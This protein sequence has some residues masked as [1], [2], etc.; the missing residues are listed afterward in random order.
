METSSREWDPGKGYKRNRF[1]NG[2]GYKC[3]RV[4]RISTNVA[5]CFVYRIYLKCKNRDQNDNPCL[6]HASCDSDIWPDTPESINNFRTNG[7]HSCVLG[8]DYAT[9]K[10]EL[11][12]KDPLFVDIPQA[13]PSGVDGPTP[14]LDSDLGP[15]ASEF[16]EENPIPILDETPAVVAVPTPVKAVSRTVVEA[17]ELT[18][19]E[20]K[21]L[22]R[23]LSGAQLIEHAAGVVNG[24]IFE[25][26]RTSKERDKLCTAVDS[27][28]E[29]ILPLLRNPNVS[30]EAVSRVP[31]EVVPV[32]TSQLRNPPVASRLSDTVVLAG[33]VTVDSIFSGAN[34]IIV[35]IRDDLPLSYVRKKWLCDQR[36]NF[37][38]L[39]GE[40]NLFWDTRP[41]SLP[42][43]EKS[44][45][46]PGQGQLDSDQLITLM[47]ILD[48]LECPRSEV[49]TPILGTALTRHQIDNLAGRTEESLSAAKAFLEEY[50]VEPVHRRIL[51][52]FPEFKC[53]EY[54]LIGQTAGLSSPGIIH[55]DNQVARS[56]SVLLPLEGSLG[57]DYF[58][59]G[60]TFH[61]EVAP[62]ECLVHDGMTLHRGNWP[63]ETKDDWFRL[64][65]QFASRPEDLAGSQTFPAAVGDP[66][67][68]PGYDAA[69]VLKAHT[70]EETDFHG[71]ITRAK[72]RRTRR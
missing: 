8:V 11:P 14:D 45:L 59:D 66:H 38:C 70:E 50:L 29:T 34:S 30:S 1:I 68:P 24:L 36:D 71:R 41:R 35:P 27:L 47:G 55:A 49:W 2:H 25:F 40:S 12:C 28:R 19:L 32:A 63:T 10:W 21:R 69:A 44:S 5:G 57:I 9:P 15:P 39:V 60:E 22:L 17:P 65:M 4:Y 52:C 16:T 31:P 37:T 67:L 43:Y 56:L 48:G 72:K 51:L 7:E 58:L 26:A 13:D 3:N 46:C 61:E 62:G 6:C 64:F 54:T 53:V 42:F 23:Y 20:I 18:L 33:G